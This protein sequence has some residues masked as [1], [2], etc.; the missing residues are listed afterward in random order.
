MKTI[1]LWIADR[2][3]EVRELLA[4][5]DLSLMEAL[6]DNGFSISATCGGSMICGTCHV[7]L[8]EGYGRA[9]TPDEDEIA[10]LEESGHY[11]ESLSRLSCQIKVSSSLV[12]L[13]VELAPEG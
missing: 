12:D 1:Q 8:A 9:G 5:P 13:K 11:R 2:D 10:L 3:G 4:E 7:Y 6:R